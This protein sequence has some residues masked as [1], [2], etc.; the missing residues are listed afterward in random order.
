MLADVLDFV[1]RGRPIDTHDTCQ[2]SDEHI[3]Q[4]LSQSNDEENTTKHINVIRSV[5]LNTPP[6]L[7][8]ILNTKYL[9]TT[10]KVITSIYVGFQVAKDNSPVVVT[11]NNSMLYWMKQVNV[12]SLMIVSETN[13]Y[14]Q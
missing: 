9:S 3:M 8:R 7:A 5:Y 2:L 11:L 13:C 4:Y 14:L 6:Q 12:S 10:E 1:F